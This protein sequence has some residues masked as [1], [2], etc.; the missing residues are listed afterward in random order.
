VPFLHSLIKGTPFRADRSLVSTQISAPI[1]IVALLGVLAAAAVGAYTF[2]KGPAGSPAGGP[3]SAAAIEQ[4]AKSVAS[5]LSGHNVATAQG[6]AD[7]TATTT[8]PAAVKPAPAA[9]KPASTRAPA[10]TTP[11]AKPAAAKAAAAKPAAAKPAAA[12]SA[13]APAAKPAPAKHVDSAKTTIAALLRTHKVVVVL[14][15]DPQAKVD[16][17]SLAEAQLGARESGAGFIGVDV[18]SQ[19]AAAP[20]TKAYGVLQDP[21]L[22]FF[23]RPG[24]LALKLTGFND[25]DVISQAIF[26]IAQQSAGAGS[27]KSR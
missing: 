12:K 16:Q 11:A 1:R 6:K 7:A 5:R 15:Y 4:Q 3:N 25:H 8:A 9:V 26:N 23:E 19:H 2:T 17:Y 18:L 20:F 14:L 21:S 13:A 22:M 27:S 24:K 10:T